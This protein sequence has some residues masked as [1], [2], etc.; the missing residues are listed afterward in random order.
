V[1]HL[2]TLAI[3]LLAVPAFAETTAKKQPAPRATDDPKLPRVLVIGD[4]ISMNYH[5]AAKSALAGAANCHR[6]EGNAASSANGVSNMELWLGNYRE[7]GFHWDVIQFNHGLHDLKQPYDAAT[8]TW[9]DYSVSPA[10]YQVRSNT[11]PG[12]WRRHCSPTGRG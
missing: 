1:K 7:K 6:N 2:S 4:S 8:D 3:L 11:P 5:E 9:G 12:R 10:D